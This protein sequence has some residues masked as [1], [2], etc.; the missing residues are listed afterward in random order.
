[1]K[2]L[3]LLK[4]GI[5]LMSCSLSAHGQLGREEVA[6]LSAEQLKTSYLMCDRR[7]A[8]EFL[9]F[10]DAV[11]C[12]HIS[13]ALK[14]KVFGGDF[15]K[16]IDWWPAHKLSEPGAVCPPEKTDGPLTE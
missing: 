7:A 6:G 13:E 11:V 12:S 5:F 15:D 1:M 16:L 9:G 4:F 10:A 8:R 2:N 14:H 3:P